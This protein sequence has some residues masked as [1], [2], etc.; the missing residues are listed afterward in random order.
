MC[1]ACKKCLKRLQADVIDPEVPIENTVGAMA[2][3][4]SQGMVHHHGWRGDDPTD[5]CRAPIEPGAY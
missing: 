1:E 4:V 5:P 2:A 3:L